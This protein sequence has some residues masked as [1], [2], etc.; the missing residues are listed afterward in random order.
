LPLAVI[1]LAAGVIVGSHR[2]ASASQSGDAPG[3]TAESERSVETGSQAADQAADQAANQAANEAAS[4][5]ADPSAIESVDPERVRK[6]KELELRRRFLPEALSA[7]ELDELAKRLGFAGEAKEM[8]LVASGRYI[9]ASSKAREERG[10]ELLRLLP[11]AFRFSSS[12]AS[13]Q[14][15]HTPELI[16]TLRLGEAIGDDVIAAEEAFARELG[17]L[18]DA[19]HRS[20][21]RR[22]RAARAET[23][24]AAPVRLPGARVNLLELL[25]KAGLAEGELASLDLV[26]DRYA[27]RYVDMLRSRHRAL[28]SNDL[29]RSEA[30]V[31]LGPEWR[32]GRTIPE[33][34]DVE[35]ELAEFDVLEVRSDSGLRDLNG[36]TIERIRKTLPPPAARRVL[37]AW[38]AI[39]HPEIFEEERL[40]R[41]LME[42]FL[43]IPSIEPEARN[44]AID[45][46]VAL[47][48]QLWPVGQQAIEL[49][50]S[51][52][53]ADRLPPTDAAQVRI[54]LE[55]QMHKL[56]TKRRKLVRDAIGLLT[57]A[58]PIELTAAQERLKDTLATLAAQDRAS[59]FIMA[60]LAR[61]DE[62]LRTLL[63]MG[64]TPAAAVQH[65]ATGVTTPPH[66]VPVGEPPA[67]DESPEAA[68][69]E[70]DGMPVAEE[71]QRTAPPKQSDRPRRDGRGSRRDG[72]R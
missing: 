61:R 42:E 50:D 21:W 27:D 16:S 6:E 4:Q 13:F 52:V 71:S 18:A 57:P 33:A 59:A 31:A 5:T 26:L 9:E 1:A 54:A 47:E 60:E 20:A 55:G 62:E 35:R 36:E 53:V 2:L 72:P 49:A 23:L 11:A 15:V 51:M 46:L 56:L 70:S 39:V 43:A 48:D 68:S 58:I 64:E 25:P 28:R 29:E 8:F 32:A 45:R 65:P 22:I 41:G 14:P 12:E 30:L 24:F 66:T 17:Q 7:E 69:P 19:A 38:Q 63:A 40:F 10:R 67:A 3:A 34:L 37:A 44:A